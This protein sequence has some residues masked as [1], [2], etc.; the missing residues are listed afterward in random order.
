MELAELYA[1]NKRLAEENAA[2]NQL[3]EEQA[4]E[5]LNKN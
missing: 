4:E 3:F 1:E 5:Q 2:L